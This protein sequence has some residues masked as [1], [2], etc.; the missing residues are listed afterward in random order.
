MLDPWFESR[1]PQALTGLG[2]ILAEHELQTSKAVDCSKYR[3]EF[4]STDGIL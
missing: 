2:K 1:S 4:A 3:F